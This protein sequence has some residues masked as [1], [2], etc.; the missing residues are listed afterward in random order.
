MDQTIATVVELVRALRHLND[1]AEKVKLFNTHSKLVKDAVSRDLKSSG[2]T[3]VLIDLAVEEEIDP[4]RVRYHPNVW[5]LLVVLISP[6]SIL[7][8]PR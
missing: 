6:A 2:V 8:R 4:D 5:S 3:K 7:G 1:H